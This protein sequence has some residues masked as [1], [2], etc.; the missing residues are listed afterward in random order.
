[1]EEGWT[2]GVGAIC[3]KHPLLLCVLSVLSVAVYTD[4]Q[5]V[6]ILILN[7]K[8]KA[9]HLAVITSNVYMWAG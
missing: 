9:G 6:K 8:H 5:F 1:M 2:F 4:R 3:F 7:L